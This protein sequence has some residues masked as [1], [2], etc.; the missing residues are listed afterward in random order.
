MSDVPG[1]SRVFLAT[2]PRIPLRSI[3][4]YHH[5]PYGLWFVARP[6]SRPEG[7]VVVITRPAG[8]GLWRAHV[9]AEER[10]SPEKQRS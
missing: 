9:L 8:S 4:G 3:L 10:V 7:S 6:S 5:T 1:E 2:L